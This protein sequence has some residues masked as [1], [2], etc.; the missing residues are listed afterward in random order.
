MDNWTPGFFPGEEEDVYHQRTLGEASNSALKILRDST[1]AHYHAWATHNDT[2]L[3]DEAK[4]ETPAQFFGKAAHMAILQPSLFDSTYIEMP[5]F[6]GKG[7]VAAKEAFIAEHPGAR[8]IKPQQLARIRGMV[9]SVLS[10]KTAR[11]IIE[12]GQS[13]VSMRWRDS[14][15]GLRAKARM[16]WWHP[17]LSFAMDLKTTDDASP[18]GFA[19][20]VANF[21]YHVQHCH[22][23]DGC[24]E[25]QQPIRNYL[26]L[27]VEKDPPYACA[28]YHIDAA[29]EE[30]G[31]Q[32]LHR[33]MD[34]LA[35]CMRTDTWPAYPEDI[36][37][38]TMPGWAFADRS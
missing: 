15:T 29:A 2:V 13:E 21:E 16:D 33:S 20:S 4:E 6:A 23:A 5:K 27:A 12:N 28:V 38:L 1:P 18:R 24:R 31:F 14:R 30:R 32:L 10:H 25:L 3:G 36:T 35:E 37:T 8:F 34:T 22:Y 11:L 9:K 19:R 17:G 26:I 7:S